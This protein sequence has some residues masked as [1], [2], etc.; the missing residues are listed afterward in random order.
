M[1]SEQAVKNIFSII[2]LVAF[3]LPAIPKSLYT[4]LFILLLYFVAHCYKLQ[5][6]YKQFKLNTISN[7]GSLRQ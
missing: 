1:F 3:I 5:V 7:Y 2:E 4:R 6:G